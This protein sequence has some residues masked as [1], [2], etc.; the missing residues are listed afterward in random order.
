MRKNQTLLV[1]FGLFILLMSSCVPGPEVIGDQSPTTP[2]VTETSVPP[3][4]TPEPLTL[5]QAA[6]QVIAALSKRDM[7]AVAEFV[8]PQQGLRFSPYTYVEEDHQIFMAETLTGLLD[9]EETYLWGHYDGTGDPI[10]LTFA[11][12]YEEFVYS[13]DFANPD[14]VAVNERLAQGNTLINI[15]EFY[16]GGSFVEYNILGTEEF[17]GMDWESLRLVFVQEGDSW[18]LVGMVHDQWTI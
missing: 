13:S 11:E 17:G 18:M 7:A 16:P 9:S 12:Y 1:V 15:Q 10:E 4:P 6:Y 3:T 8:H 5:E 2:P 14:Q